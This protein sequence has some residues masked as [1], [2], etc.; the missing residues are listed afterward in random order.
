MKL[1]FQYGTEQN[2]NAKPLFQTQHLKQKERVTCTSFVCGV[3]GGD[4]PFISRAKADSRFTRVF[5]SNVR[6]VQSA[7]E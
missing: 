7:I 4:F 3:G 2:G 6:H 1:E 5:L